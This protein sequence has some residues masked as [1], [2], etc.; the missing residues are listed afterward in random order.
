M[1]SEPDGGMNGWARPK[2]LGEILGLSRMVQ[3]KFHKSMRERVQE[4]D[5]FSGRDK[6]GLSVPLVI[7]DC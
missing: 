7:Q 2:E 4:I 1:K 3:G 6:V 5:W